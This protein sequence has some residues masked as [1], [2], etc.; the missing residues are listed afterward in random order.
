M[1]I[2]TNPAGT[3]FFRGYIDAVRISDEALFPSGF[4]A[5]T[6]FF[7]WAGDFS[8]DWNAS[9]NWQGG[10]YLPNSNLHTVIFGNVLSSTNTVFTDLDVAVN[11]LVFNDDS[12]YVLA[13]GGGIHMETDP[14]SGTSIKPKVQVLQGAH[15]FQA[16][17][18]LEDNTRIELSDNTTL[19]FQNVIHLGI[20]SLTIDPVGAIQNGVANINNAVTGTGPLVNNATISAGAATVI[21][22]DFTNTGTLQVDLA[23]GASAA[24]STSNWNPGTSLAHRSPC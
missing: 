6:T 2:G 24:Y 16:A 8:G 11:Q 18:H 15:E 22:G 4:L 9:A 21:G 10:G 23:A 13:G 3:K 1:L 17:L 20:Y 12:R 14:G 19:D 7:N 5:D